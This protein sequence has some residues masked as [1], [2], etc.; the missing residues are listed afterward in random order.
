MTLTNGAVT[1]TT[2]GALRPR[3][4]G[5][6]RPIGLRWMDMARSIMSSPR[7]TTWIDDAALTPTQLEILALTLG[8]FLPAMIADLVGTT[9]PDVLRQIRLSL[10]YLA[11][12]A[13]AA[14]RASSAGPPD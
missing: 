4:A 9:R 5:D 11:A 12:T 7:S 1:D 14:G 2:I 10:G 13:P 3:A 6:S 8:G